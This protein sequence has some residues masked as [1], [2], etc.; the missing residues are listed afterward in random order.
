MCQRLFL[1]VS[2]SAT[3]GGADFGTGGGDYVF[4]KAITS[5]SPKY[6]GWGGSVKMI[7]DP[8]EFDRLDA[9]LHTSDGYGNT[10]P[11]NSGYGD[12]S[13]RKP[14]EEAASSAS[15][16]CFKQA[17]SSRKL[18]KIAVGSKSTATQLIKA[19]KERGVTSINGMTPE[20]LVYVQAGA[21]TDYKAM[22][23]PAGY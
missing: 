23:K 12:W 22:F 1:G 6:S 10:N 17:I 21:D 5:K 20:E 4:T 19:L 7:Y 13:G 8:S 3:S 11:K 16:I 15:E 14:L 18:L 2:D 9:F